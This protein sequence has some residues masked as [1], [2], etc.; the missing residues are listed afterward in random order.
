MAEGYEVSIR[1]VSQQGHC[2]YGHKVGDEWLVGDTTPA[3]ICTWA[4]NSLYPA[5]SVLMY[6]GA[7]PWESDPDA[8]TIAC[9]DAA[10]PV[11]FELKRL[12]E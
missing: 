3:G 11:V 8:T 7:F 1:V 5:L 12:R 9:P 6:G 4:F 10:N 2:A